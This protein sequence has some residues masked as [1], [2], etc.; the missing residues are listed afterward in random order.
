MTSDISIHYSIY[1]II[2]VL[3]SLVNRIHP[4]VSRGEVRLSG[5]DV[6]PVRCFLYIWTYLFLRRVG[7][8]AIKCIMFERYVLKPFFLDCDI[9]EVAISLAATAL[10]C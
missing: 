2:S 4:H 8:N 5:A 7:T 9:P 1:L 6:R 10:A 3:Y